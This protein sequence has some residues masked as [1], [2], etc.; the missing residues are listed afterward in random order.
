MKKETGLRAVPSPTEAGSKNSPPAWS[1]ALSESE[2][3]RPGGMLLAALIST[4]SD[5]RQQLNDMSRD[6]GVTY[7]Y[8]NQL[9]NGTR[10]VDQISDNFALS[11]ALY[12]G[13]PRLTVLFL[14]GRLTP[15]DFFESGQMLLSEVTRAMAF[16]A[17]DPEWGPLFTQELRDSSVQSQFTLVR[18]FEKATGR[19]LMSER[20]VPEKLAEQV[21]SFQKVQEERAAALKEAQKREA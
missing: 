9:R 4:A 2:L 15:E 20:L 12:L 14:A 13:V 19:V 21:A 3:S 8:I 6:L 10:R 1:G 5:R 11:C 16:I 17:E 18:L 7:G